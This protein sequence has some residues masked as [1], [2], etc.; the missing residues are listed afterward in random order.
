MRIG[1]AVSVELAGSRR[2]LDFGDQFQSCFDLSPDATLILDTDGTL[3]FVNS[4]AEEVFGYRREAM[5]GRNAEMLLPERLRAGHADR[6]ARYFR[7]LRTR[8]MGFSLEITGL[9]ADGSEFPVDTRLAPMNKDGDALLVVAMRDLSSSGQFAQGRA[10]LAAIVEFSDDAIFSKDLDGRIITWNR[11]AEKLYGFSA[12]EAIGQHVAMITPADRLDEVPTLLD[13]ARAGATAHLETVRNRKDG[14]SVDVSLTISPILDAGGIAVGASVSAR[15]L[16]EQRRHQRLR[17]DFIA[18]AAHELRTPLTTLAGLGETLALHFDVMARQDIEDAFSAMAR[19]GER[20]RVL[21]TNLLDLSKIEGG[22][23]TFDIVDVEIR[24]LIDRVLEAAPPP[25]DNRVVVTVP[26]DLVLRADP[27]RLEQVVTNLLVNAYRYGGTA[28][29]VG[30][31]VHGRR[32][33]F[34]VDDDGRGVEL[35]FVGEL[36]EPFTRGREATAVR[37]SGIGLALCRRIVQGMDGQIDYEP[38]APHGSRFTV[39]LRSKR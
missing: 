34:W 28:I 21:I 19:Q 32:A 3:V 9:H 22:R 4:Q 38:V 36:F 20:A 26:E 7:E 10:A 31:T 1:S 37:G 8:P 23:A 13:R 14:T 15:D 2:S 16:T 25:D 17:E 24:Q 30:A 12:D 5:L 11:A 33:V 39:T 27:A 29:R 18:N 6:R 35:D